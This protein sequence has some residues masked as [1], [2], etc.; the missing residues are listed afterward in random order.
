MRLLG[1]IILG[2]AKALSSRINNELLKPIGIWPND[3]DWMKKLQ[4][5]DNERPDWAKYKQQSRQWT[6][7]QKFLAQQ[8]LKLYWQKIREK[9]QYRKKISKVLYTNK[10]NRDFKVEKPLKRSIDTA[11]LSDILAP[12]SP[13]EKHR[14]KIAFEF[15]Q[16]YKLSISDLLPWK[17]IIISELTENGSTTLN[18]MR[19]HFTENK[20]LDKI[21]KFQHLLQMVMDGEINLKQSEHVGQIQIVPKSVNQRSVIKIK[22]KSGQSYNF[23]WSSLNDAQRNKII[24]D[25]IERK[26]LCR[27]VDCE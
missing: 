9:R 1:D 7:Q 27:S 24:T 14:A 25:A 4:S 15:S 16:A 12:F 23:K 17:T 10:K 18:D 2:Q 8:R 19:I 13:I 20:R 11:F 6:K 21:S 22:D 3:P 26:I 5:Q